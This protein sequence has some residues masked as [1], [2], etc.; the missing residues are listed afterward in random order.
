M[1]YNQN[2]LS[3]IENGMQESRFDRCILDDEIGNSGRHDR[4]RR[5]LFDFSSEKSLAPVAITRSALWNTSTSVLAEYLAAI[6]IEEPGTV[7]PSLIKEF[8][9][10]ADV[11]TASWWQL[12]RVVGPRLARSLRASHGLMV[13]MLEEQVVDAP[14][15]PR[16][17]ELV[18][19]LHA[20]IGFLKHERL[21]ALYVDSKVRLMR[22]EPVADG[23]FGQAPIDN[24]RVIGC[25]L[26]V[27]ASGFIL[28]HNHPSGIPKPSTSDICVTRRL[29]ELASQFDLA[30]LDHFIVAR[31]QFGTIED[32]WREARWAEAVG[33]EA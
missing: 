15:V 13:A 17:K 12:R 11:V 30:L 18:D 8:G 10:L 5:P 31:G 23:G 27:G 16:S 3:R 32:Y 21:L 14:V 7:A 2:G 19:L 9:T 6:G 29:K 4:E 1:V 24:R 26:A 33:A 22:I 20:E 28:V 25:A